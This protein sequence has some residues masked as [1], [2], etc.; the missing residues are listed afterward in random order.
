MS[1]IKI[2]GSKNTLIGVGDGNHQTGDVTVT[3]NIGQQQDYKNS[4]EVENL[5]N[6][7]P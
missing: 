5:L 7:S 2:P 1:E 6:L 3:N 4:Q